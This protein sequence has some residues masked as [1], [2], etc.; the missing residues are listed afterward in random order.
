M[1]WVYLF[2][3]TYVVYSTIPVSYDDDDDDDDN[4]YFLMTMIY[5][6]ILCA[7]DKAFDCSL[8]GSD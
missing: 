1:L 7:G 8:L 5:M 3:S 6:Y 4:D 2:S